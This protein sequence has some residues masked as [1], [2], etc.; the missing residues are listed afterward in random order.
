MVDALL[1]G[2]YLIAEPVHLE[3]LN[4]LFVPRE[5]REG[6]GMGIEVGNGIR[7]K[8]RAPDVVTLVHKGGVSPWAKARQF[9]EVPLLGRW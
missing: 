3:G 1:S 2:P 7:T 8:I 9:V 4:V 6:L 5:N